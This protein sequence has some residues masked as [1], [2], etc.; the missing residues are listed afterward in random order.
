MFRE[1]TLRGARLDSKPKIKRDAVPPEYAAEIP[2]N[3]LSKKGESPEAYASLFG[4]ADGKEFLDTIA[5]FQLARGELGPKKYFEKIVGLRVQKEM[6]REFGSPGELIKRQADD[7]VFNDGNLGLLHQDTLA[8][9]AKLGQEHSFTKEDVKRQMETRLNTMKMKDANFKNSV[10]MMYR[11]GGKLEDA[12][13]RDDPKTAYQQVQRKENGYALAVGIKKLEKEQKGHERLVKAYRKRVP[14]GRDQSFTPFV[15]D[16]LERIGESS[17][18]RSDINTE[19]AATEW[20]SLAKLDEWF[21]DEPYE[22]KV[23]P[24]FLLDPNWRGDPRLLTVEQW[25]GINDTVQFLDKWSRDNQAYI[26]ANNRWDFRDLIDNKLVPAIIRTY[27]AL[28]GTGAQALMPSKPTH[29]KAVF[30]K[31]LQMELIFNWWDRND[32][33]GIA[34]QSIVREYATAA[35]RSDSLDREFGSLLKKLSWIENPHR[36]VKQTLF[37]N[38]DTGEILDMTKMNLLGILANMGNPGNFFTMLD[39]FK[40]PREMAGA[41]HKLVFDNITRDDVVRMIE[42]G[43]IF[44]KAKGMSDRMYRQM[45]G[46]APMNI[47]KWS[48]RTPYTDLGQNGMI[49][50]WYYPIIHDPKFKQ[51]SEKLAAPS[52]LEFPYWTKSNLPAAGYTKERTG[53]KGP[54]LLNMDGLPNR[55]Q[56]IVRDVAWR[57]ALTNLHKI[58]TDPTFRA[59]VKNHWGEHYEALLDPFLKDMAGQR[60]T[61]DLNTSIINHSLQFVRQ[62]IISHMVGLKPTTIAKHSVT[63]LVQSINRV[64]SAD[65]GRALFTVWGKNAETGET[66]WTF[67]MNK[68]EELQRRHRNYLEG[69]TGNFDQTFGHLKVAGDMREYL[70]TFSREGATQ[71]AR[72]MM[73][74]WKAKYLG[75]R[76]SMHYAEAYPMAFLDLMSA[77]P[78]WLARYRQAKI[79]GENEGMAIFMADAAVRDAHGSSAVTSRPALMRNSPMAQVFGNF[80]TF[81]SHI[82]S[83][84]IEFAWSI[85]ALM[86]GEGVALSN[87]KLR[88]DGSVIPPE[89]ELVKKGDTYQLEDEYKKSDAFKYGM[90]AVAPMTMMFIAYYLFPA[91]W[92]EYVAPMHGE[93]GMG[94]DKH[95]SALWYA[96]KVQAR[97]LS[98]SWMYLRDVAKGVIEGGDVSAGLMG[99]AGK[100]IYNI[101]R[102]TGKVAHQKHLTLDQKQ[103]YIKHA[104]QII[105]FF[106]GVGMPDAIPKMGI[107]G[108]N[109]YY[110]KEHPKTIRE[111][112]TGINR[113]TSHPKHH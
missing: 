19:M 100:T 45:Y 34:N 65:F 1:G 29:L 71:A 26:T 9:A 61:I 99:E 33:R 106:G 54:V 20:G 46:V 42:I 88:K 48:I 103:A 56:M 6:E 52:P 21:R 92:D 14:D 24:E 69:I 64:G 12:L 105:N 102:D 59:A 37:R 22:I 38:P 112:W 60:D 11:A 94:P 8:M 49:E 2:Q 10:T 79:A 107:F 53:Y 7:H 30:A 51:T 68:S 43:K 74:D 31:S 82:L 108:Y 101:V 25:R 91:W 28:K 47:D 76:D 77:V 55:L 73:G 62:N 109:W 89:L 97:G 81:F 110:R 13:L 58:F 3:W 93:K 5:Q 72:L 67:A 98:A 66:N 57:P 90:S 80:Y 18:P 111:Y 96:T 17:R 36:L 4:L 84:Q 35:N 70:N 41:V 27:P 86:K 104:N 50:G 83:R 85:R 40:I 78:T 113:G 16:I 44:D 39:S 95:E 15:H 32:R 75:I 23:I 63:A 87:P